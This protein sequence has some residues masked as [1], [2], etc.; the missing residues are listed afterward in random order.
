MD[1][2]TWI[3]VVG[4]CLV[5]QAFSA[6]AEVALGAANRGRLRQRAEAGSRAARTAER[7][8]ARPEIALATTLLVA[9]L[10]TLVAVLVSALFL[11]GRGAPMA[12]AVAVVP[13]MLVLGQIVPKALVQARA[14]RA[15]VAI[16]P[17]LAVLSWVLR[18]AVLVVSGFASVLTRLWGLDQRRSFV[19]R[20]ELALL[21]ESE[22]ETDK[23]EI[24]R[25]RA[26]DDRERVRARRVPRRRPHGAAVRG[27]GAARGSADRRGRR[28]DRRQ[29]A[30]ADAD[31]SA[32][33][34]T[35]SSASCTC[36]TSCGAGAD[37][38]PQPVSSAGAPAD[39]R[40]RERSR[41]PS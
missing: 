14:D 38:R 31:L 11:R 23:P 28:R 12:V 40:A 6:S 9:N 19:S 27:H 22:P 25:R 20:D 8:A 41:R 7:L 33:A 10:S 15:V 37:K 5:V 17:A 29:A 18:P 16:A 34:S 1:V 35:T 36:S 13:P 39:L 4:A 32:A 3:L 21:I 2:D 26:R 30:L 24:E